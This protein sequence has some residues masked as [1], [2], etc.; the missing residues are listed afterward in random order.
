MEKDLEVE[1]LFSAGN[2]A[3]FTMHPEPGR[4]YRVIGVYSA[5]EQAELTRRW[6]LTS[7]RNLNAPKH[8][9]ARCKPR[10]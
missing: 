2:L 5:L 4:V 10:P 3:I 8:L 9:S 7:K 6:F 1:F